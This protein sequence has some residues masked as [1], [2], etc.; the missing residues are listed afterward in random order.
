MPRVLGLWMTTAIVVGTV[1]G[2]GVFKKGR[3]VSE[4]V[5]EFGLAMVVWVLGGVLALLGALALSEV[6][7]LMPRA[8]GNY[9]FLR[10]AYGR[11]AGFLYG[12]VEFWIIRAASIAALATMFTESFHDAL[13]QALYPGE[14]VELIAFWPRQLLTA[15]VIVGLAAVNARGTR[16]GGG[17]QFFITIL[18]VGSLLFII[19]LPF[20][21]Y[22]FVSE[23]TY[24][25]KLEHLSPTWPPDFLGINWGKFG[26]ALIGVLWAY[27]GWMAIAPVAE[28]VKNPQRNIPLGLLGGVMLLIGL[29]CGAN[30]AY[31]LVLPRDA[32]IAKD[33]RGELSTT[34]LATQFFLALIGPI[35]AV[36][37][38]AIIMTSVFGALN[39]NLL[40][41]PRLLY[42]MGKDG[43]A[44]RRLSDIHPR[45]ETPVLAT[46]V[47]TVWSVLLVLGVGALTQ[48]T[49]PVIPLGFT[50]LDLNLQK[51]KSPFDVMTDFAVFGSVTF[52][53]LAVASIFVFRRR[54]PITPENRPYRCWG[55]PLVPLLYIA[56]MGAVIFTFFATPESR[57]EAFIG[58]GFIGLGAVVYGVLFRRRTK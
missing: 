57:S 41:G 53:T 52:E 36:V 29:Y 16:L 31:D 54:I 35:G 33:E 45:Y 24:P 43:L 51:G 55:Y 27:H 56:G 32:I 17:L 4:N 10:E 49:V 5:P 23:P 18:K 47:L 30:I 44:P 50:E 19:A 22:A 9:V 58:V 13:K 26:T 38:S 28:E 12:W 7:V 34:P 20:A 25:P 2:S 48:Y 21:V 14:K 46:I 1:I 15:F 37:A 11:L 6:A 39:G 8:G 3:I 42:A 40:V